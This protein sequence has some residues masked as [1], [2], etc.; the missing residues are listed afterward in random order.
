M[1]PL[2]IVANFK[3]NKTLAEITEWI[4][5]FKKIAIPE[6]KEIVVCPSFPYLYQ[7]VYATGKTNF[8]VGAQDLSRFPQGEHTGEVNGSQIKEFARYVIVGHSERR[9][10]ED[11]SVIEEKVRIALDYGLIPIL[12]LQNEAGKL[13]PGVS[14][15]AYE[16]TSAIGTGK[17]DTSENADEVA[18]KIKDIMEV[19][20]LYGGSVTQ[21]NVK[22]FTSMRNIDGVLVGG[23]SLSADEFSK[24]VENA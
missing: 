3:S 10:F 16:P 1:K 7:F 22:N 2:L 20:V 12:C 11:E 5:T 9:A 17:P 13:Y 15:V 19:K 8:I 21:E 4:E 14:I 24:I 23:A 6:G 18:K